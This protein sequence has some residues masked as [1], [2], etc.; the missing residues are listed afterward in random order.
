MTP[1]EQ[2][3]QQVEERWRPAF[4]TFIDTGEASQDF[5]DF[6]DQNEKAQRALDEALR[7]ETDRLHAMGGLPAEPAA[8][9]DRPARRPRFWSAPAFQ[10]LA[11]AAAVAFLPCLAV[12]GWYEFHGPDA[13]MRQVA[14][15]PA[16]NGSRDPAAELAQA[17]KA[18]TTLAVER[19]SSPDLKVSGD[20]V[21]LLAQIG[22]D[23][24]V[25]YPNVV[26]ALQA[27]KDSAKDPELSKAV[28]A[29]IWRID[30]TAAA[31]NAPPG[32]SGMGSWVAPYVSK[33]APEDIAA[34]QDQLID[35]EVGKVGSE[36]A[37]AAD[38]AAAAQKLEKWGDKAKR[39][40][41]TLMRQLTPQQDPDVDKAVRSAQGHRPGSRQGGGRRANRRG[42]SPLGLIGTE[43][44]RGRGSVSGRSG[45][46]AG[47]GRPL[48]QRASVAAAKALKKIGAASGPAVFVIQD[49]LKDEEDPAVRA[50]MGQALQTIDPA[51]AAIIGRESTPAAAPAAS[52]LPPN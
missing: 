10:R 14:F 43:E 30:P 39:A 29:A 18:A 41:P 5:L 15:L 19:L 40:V 42:E 2:L 25:D 16:N 33:T 46:R 48:P 24:Q 27:C 21:R 7:I 6:L 20:A 9:P 11:V 12:L 23:A 26:E 34:G 4:W 31:P 35:V 13:A 3:E 50:A 47:S 8:P 51:A 32:T 1:K 44:G 22:P 38:R 17:R 28:D 49:K 45:R 36:S 37:S 52:A